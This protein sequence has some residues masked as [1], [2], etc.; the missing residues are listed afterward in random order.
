MPLQNRRL[1]WQQP[2]QSKQKEIYVY[3]EEQLIDAIGQLVIETRD[4]PGLAKGYF[5]GKIIKIGKAFTITS[6]IVIPNTAVG[7]II[8]GTR[9]SLTPGTDDM[10]C[11]QSSAAALTIKDLYLGGADSLATAFFGT[12]VKLTGN[13]DSVRI[14]DNH[15]TGTRLVDGRTANSLSKLIIRNNTMSVT[16]DP[17]W[18]DLVEATDSVIQGNVFNQGGGTNIGVILG[19]NCESVAVNGNAFDGCSFD[20]SGSAGFNAIVGNTDITI[21]ATAGSDVSAGNT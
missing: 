4:F 10:V 17:T 8:D 19:S 1:P 3:S 7:L 15:I 14:L 13:S 20:S 11:F 9:T 12:L 18:I 2:I 16:D 21:T 6:T 5:P